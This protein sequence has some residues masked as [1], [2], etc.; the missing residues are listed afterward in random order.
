[1][2]DARLL[3]ALAYRMSTP[4]IPDL[5]AYTFYERDIES[6][7][8]LISEFEWEVPE[9]FNIAQ[10]ACDRWAEDKSKVALFGS[11]SDGNRTTYTYWEL[12][13][14]TNQLANYL[15]SQG[16]EKGD[17]VGVN[18][19][20]KPETAIAH[21]A[22][23]KA[24][25]ISVPLS[26]KF[27]P[28]ALKHRIGDSGAK[29]CIADTTNVDAIR[30]VK[31]EVDAMETVLVEGTEAAGQDEVRFWDVIAEASDDFELVDTAA[32]D[33]AV[34]IYTSGTT[35]K[36]KGVRHAHR[37][38]IGH[39]PQFI[40][41]VC[42]MS[43]TQTDVV[44]TPA[45]WAWIATVMASMTP[46]LYHGIPVVAHH[47]DGPFDPESAFRIIDEYGVTISF[48]PPTALRMMIEKDHLV[49]NY[50]LDSMRVITSG[51]ESLG[52]D[53][54]TWCENAFDGVKIHE[55]YGQT[56]AN[57]LVSDST[58]LFPRRPGR[59]GRPMPGHEVEILDPETHQ[60]M[61]PGETGEISVRYESDPIC[62]KEYWNKPDKTAEKVQDGWL[63]TGDLGSADEDGYVKFEG[64]KDDVIITAG[65][66]IGPD[67]IEDTLA[68]HDAV[69]SA[70]V[71]GI[72]DAE[73]GEVPKAFVTISEG[74]E[75]SSQLRRDLQQ[76]VKDQ[77][78]RYEYPREIE[79]VDA[80]P[81]TATG[82]IQ[83][84]KLREREGIEP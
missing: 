32:E 27:G 56:E 10:Y 49:D 26:T 35:G 22:V 21:L 59:M 4:T 46:A 11:D 9:Q 47:E 66:R 40:A 2:S 65:Y 76:H 58:T 16:I 53:I 31:N 37:G 50:T 73:R 83:R 75:P 74:T 41:S 72:P 30:S 82:K 77:L 23:W 71:I 60:P 69:V 84:A 67:E 33:D 20:Q 15:T 64:R 52:T 68:T 79:F 43:I 8:H 29:A 19:P 25:A 13:R 54:E 7:D 18:L 3:K 28:E 55:V 81:T 14:L 62:F 5:E 45:E 39:F 61:E 38:F 36:P 63:L 17:R 12:R 44:W 1:L 42:D 6:Y 34:I 57:T 48:F 24:G 80:F 78:A 51:G 70:A